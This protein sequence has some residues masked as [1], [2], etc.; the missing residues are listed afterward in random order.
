[1]GTTRSLLSD[2]KDSYSFKIPADYEMGFALF[3]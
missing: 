1:M 3:T 2:D